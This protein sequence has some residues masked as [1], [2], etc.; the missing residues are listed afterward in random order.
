MR[1]ATA[2]ATSKYRETRFETSI[3]LP[4][5]RYQEMLSRMQYAPTSSGEEFGVSSVFAAGGLWA[6][7]SRSLFTPRSS[8]HVWLPVKGERRRSSITLPL[9]SS[10][11]P[12]LLLV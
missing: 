10:I 3:V 4:I 12:A 7:V 2:D 5:A 6:Y 11:V 1:S 8:R 9:D